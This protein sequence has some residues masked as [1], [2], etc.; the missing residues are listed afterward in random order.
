VIHQTRETMLK[1]LSREYIPF[2]FNIPARKGGYLLIS[3]F[4][5]NNKSPVISRRYIRVGEMSEY[6][7]FEVKPRQ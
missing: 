4:T 3:E 1:A 5:G 7:Y 6:S 2:S